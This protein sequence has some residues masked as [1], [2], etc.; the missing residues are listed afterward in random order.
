MKLHK[1]MLSIRCTNIGWESK[2]LSTFNG[3]SLKLSYLILSVLC[4]T[5]THDFPIIQGYKVTPC[6]NN[7]TQG[8]QKPSIGRP[9]KLN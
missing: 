6:Y 9:E 5:T 1:E 4:L 2:L 8:L 3:T 7:S